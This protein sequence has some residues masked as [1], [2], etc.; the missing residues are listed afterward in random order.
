MDFLDIGLTGQGLFPKTLKAYVRFADGCPVYAAQMLDLGDISPTGGA[1]TPS[2]PGGDPGTSVWNTVRDIDAVSGGKHPLRGGW[3]CWA[4][5]AQ[6]AASDGWA[7]FRGIA[8]VLGTTAITAGDMMVAAATDALVEC[9][10]TA[11]TAG[12]DGKIVAIAIAAF[13][14][15]SGVGKAVVDGIS[16]FGSDTTNTTA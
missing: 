1:G 5:E 12:T 15:T 2:V 9:T 8:D 16:G 11:T 14:T 7:I 13:D 3:I 6:G 10:S 4:V